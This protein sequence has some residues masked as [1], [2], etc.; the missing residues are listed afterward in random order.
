MFLRTVA[1]IF[2]HPGGNAS[3]EKILQRHRHALCVTE[4]FLYGSFPLNAKHTGTLKIHN[5]VLFLRGII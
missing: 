1:A 5:A 4:T 3:A 2:I